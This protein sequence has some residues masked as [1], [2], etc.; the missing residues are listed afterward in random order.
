MISIFLAAILS[1][2]THG[3]RLTLDDAYM[4]RELHTQYI[5]M[6]P[7]KST[8]TTDS[9]SQVEMD[10]MK[11]SSSSLTIPTDDTSHLQAH[12]DEVEESATKKGCA[13]RPSKS[14]VRL[15][16]ESFLWLTIGALFAIGT[17]SPGDPFLQE[18]FMVLT[19]G[20]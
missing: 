7:P 6:N 11:R 9:C 15:G 1:G 4:Y 16:F 8:S 19:L 2:A 3:R 12:G 5:D 13:P 10:S 17:M 18:I 20:S 14:W